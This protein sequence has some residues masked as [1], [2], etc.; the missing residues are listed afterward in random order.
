MDFRGSQSG[1]WGYLDMDYDVIREPRPG[2]SLVEFNGSISGEFE[3][4]DKISIVPPHTFEEWNCPQLI[5]LDND[6]TI[7]SIDISFKTREFPF[8]FS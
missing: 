4:V 7:N 6:Q 3:N 2:G 1:N 5:D 8:V